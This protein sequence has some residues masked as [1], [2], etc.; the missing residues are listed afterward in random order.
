MV[1]KTKQP[2]ITLT[3]RYAET[4]HLLNALEALSEDKKKSV[5]HTTLERQLKLIK[6][7][8]LKMERDRKARQKAVLKNQKTVLKRTTS[9][10]RKT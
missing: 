6:D 2:E 1:E 10:T 4:E 9:R 5:T 8:W 7:H 3:L